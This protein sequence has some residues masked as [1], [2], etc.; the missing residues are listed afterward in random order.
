MMEDIQINPI[1]VH[2]C[3]HEIYDS[4]GARLRDNGRTIHC[5][6]D[7]ARPKIGAKSGNLTRISTKCLRAVGLQFI[8]L[9]LCDKAGT[10]VSFHDL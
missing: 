9:Y 8:R 1:L 3:S 7:L 2:E 4:C 10:S 5:L 6:M